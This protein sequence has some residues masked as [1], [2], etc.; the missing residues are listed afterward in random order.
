MT[1]ETKQIDALR[2]VKQVVEKEYCTAIA[3]IGDSGVSRTYLS[4][5]MLI[6]DLVS[7]EITRIQ[8]MAK[9][10]INPEACSQCLGGKIICSVTG[11]PWTMCQCRICEDGPVT[12]LSCPKCSDGV[13]PAL[14]SKNDTT[15]EE[16]S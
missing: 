9:T 16:K 3:L 10:K 15:Q 5:Y 11:Q 4:A 12:R 8:N 1:P 14:W 13:V 2:W 7:A 6:L